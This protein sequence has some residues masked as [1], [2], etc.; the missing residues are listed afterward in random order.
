M[1]PAGVSSLY[2]LRLE[3][4]GEAMS[5]MEH[6]SSLCS[7]LEFHRARLVAL[8]NW[9]A[10][11]EA[12]AASDDPVGSV[13]RALGI[14]NLGAHSVIAMLR[15]HRPDRTAVEREVRRLECLEAVGRKRADVRRRLAVA[16]TQGR[17]V[18]AW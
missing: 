2:V 18:L 14:T 4:I 8:D 16:R 7:V 6:K 13:S 10:A 3:G 12:L 17:D 5:V 11:Q 15:A 1:S 9:N